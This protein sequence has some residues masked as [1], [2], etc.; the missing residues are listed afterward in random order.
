M[1]DFVEWVESCGEFLGWQ[2]G[3]FAG[4]YTRQQDQSATEAV[5][6]WPLLDPLLG[7]LARHGGY[8]EGTVGQLLAALNAAQGKAGQPRPFEWPRSPKKL[9]SDLSRY[10][11]A[12]RRLGVVVRKG[13]KGRDGRKLVIAFHP[14]RDPGVAVG[15]SVT[16]QTGVTVEGAA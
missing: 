8:W 7:L 11:P 16:P 10:S 1:L 3:A 4:V 15:A 12:L 9:S 6:M 13:A 5:E 14:P 2:A